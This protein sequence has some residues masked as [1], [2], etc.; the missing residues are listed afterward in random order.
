MSSSK[1]F[2][3]C[4]KTKS[5]RIAEKVANYASSP[6]ADFHRPYVAAKVQGYMSIKN[7]AELGS[8]VTAAGQHLQDI[9][10]YTQRAERDDAKIRF[11]RGVMKTAGEYR[12]LCPGYLDHNKTSSCAYAFMYLDVLWWLTKRTD[13]TLTAKEM[14]LKSAIITLATI[15][16]AALTMKFQPG[17]GGNQD[18]K[19][20]LNSALQLG[21]IDD[22]DRKELSKLWD[23]RNNVHLKTLDTSEFGKYVAD[24]VDLPRA[25]LDRMLAALVK[26]NERRGAL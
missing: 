7:D 22:S 21:L 16:E 6:D 24:D 13:I 15:A 20:R 23:N 11:P 9:H 5:V 25:A 14:A 2:E 26:W 19:N 1:I 10:D 8:A 3:L 4:T 18:F 12:A 17:F